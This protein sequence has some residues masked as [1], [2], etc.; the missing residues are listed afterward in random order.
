MSTVPWAIPSSVRVVSFPVRKR[1]SSA[2]RTGQGAKRSL[3]V[4]ACCSASSVENGHLL[5]AHHGHEGRAK[6]HFGLSKA[7]VSAHEPVHGTARRHVFEH[8]PDGR[9]LIGGFLEGEAF[10]KRF[11]VGG[12]HLEG[13]ART[14]LTQ[15][16]E[17]QQFRRRVAHL[18]RGFFLGLPPVASPERME[19]R[20]FGVGAAVGRNQ[21]QIRNG[22]EEL[23]FVFVFQLQK[24]G[25]SLV[26][27]HLFE[28]EIAADP[29]LQVD[30]RVAHLEFGDVANEHLDVRRLRAAA[31]P[32]AAGARRI[33]FRLG[34]K[35]DLRMMYARSLIERSGRK[36]HGDVGRQ[37]VVERVEFGK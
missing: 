4:W 29:V 8:G 13:K 2:T 27:R 11:V 33:E 22:Y 10:G 19:R 9:G 32:R 23:R 24:F 17:V 6:R 16:V 36:S 30:D 21:V 37:K 31:K 7:H 12:R 18:F 28:S 34:E 26:R 1:E 25:F 3:K 20:V 5:A 14:A 35:R 15:G